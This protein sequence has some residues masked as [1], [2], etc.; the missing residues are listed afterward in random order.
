MRRIIR[1]TGKSDAEG[2]YVLLNTGPGVALPSNSYIVTEDQ[3][4][5]LRAKGIPFVEVAAENGALQER[6]MPLERV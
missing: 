1:F 4:A 3:I 2:F 6:G 5:A